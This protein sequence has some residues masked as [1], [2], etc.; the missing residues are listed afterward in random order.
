MRSVIMTLLIA[1]HSTALYVGGPGRVSGPARAAMHSSRREVG[2]RSLFLPAIAAAAFGLTLNPAVAAGDDPLVKIYFGAGCFWHVQHELVLAERA[3]LGRRDAEFTAVSG[4]AGGTRV[5]SGK[6]AGPAG[7]KVCYHNPQGVAD[8]G[9]LGHAEVVQ[10][11]VPAS[12]VSDFAFKYFSL[13]GARGLRHDPQDRGGEYRSVLGL[14]GGEASPL[15]AVIAAAAKPTPMRLATG[16]GDEGDTIG[17]KTVLVYDSDAFSFYPA[18][19]YHQFHNDFMDPPYGAA[20]NGLLPKLYA[21]KK[22]GLVGCPDLDPATIV[23][24]RV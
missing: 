15:Y 23:E 18:E 1:A 13:F 22:I 17:D 4:Y 12:R 21:H 20:Y 3:L 19:L 11:E 16:A 10:V 5:A 2:R 24:G 8:Y 7:A 14:P 9:R 6:L